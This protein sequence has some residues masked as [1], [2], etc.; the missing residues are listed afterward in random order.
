MWQQG[1]SD[2]QQFLDEPDRFQ[3][4][5]AGSAAVLRGCEEAVAAFD[6]S[7]FPYFARALGSRE[8]WRAWPEFR[9]KTVYLDIET[10]GGDTGDAIT[11]IGMYDG[12]RF[13][14][15]VR[16]QDLEQ[17]PEIIE[18]Y[19]MI[20]TFYGAGFDLPMLKKAFRGIRFDQVHLDLCFAFRQLGVRGGLKKIEKQM[21]IGRGDETDGLTGLDAI[22]LWREYER[23]SAASLETLIEYNREDV[24]NLETL[25]QILYQR[26]RNRAWLAAGLSLSELD[27][28]AAEG[29]LRLF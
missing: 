23:G 20:V 15:L 8:S 4:G 28:E 3:V 26:M 7:D 2:W 13:V 29:N 10:D 21:G 12:N 24:V 18:Q 1:C 11:T 27:G 9:K 19:G 14:C 17:F 16:D 5:S 25:T 22:R 6:R